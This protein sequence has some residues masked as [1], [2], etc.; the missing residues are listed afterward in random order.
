MLP[1]V[2]FARHLSLTVVAALASFAWIGDAF[3]VDKKPAT[4]DFVRDIRPLLSDNCFACHGPDSKKRKADLRL[5]TRE[6]AFA[7]LGGTTTIVHG[8]PNESELVI[9]IITD[10]ED[11]LMPPSDSGKKL[12]DSQKAL[13]KQWIVEGAQYDLHWAYKPITRPMPPSVKRGSFVVNDI[14]RLVLA[15][16]RAKGYEPAWEADR[17]TL[18][19]RLSFDLTGLP[20]TWEQVQSFVGDS[21]LH[22]F[23]KLVDRLLASPHYGERM[24]AFWLDLVRYAD[25]M[26]YH[27][28]NEQTK[29]LYREYVINAFNN[30]LPFDR[31]TR[32]QL[33]GDLLPD[34][35]RQQL[36]ASGYNRLN[37][38]TREGGSQ[39]KE[40]IAIYLGDRVRNVS[41]VWMATTLNC[42]ECHDHKFDPFSMRDY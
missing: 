8:K 9:R 29:P 31:F 41:A 38:T 14:D 3:A 11:D 25:T 40:Y 22:A 24:A 7:D 28:D 20:P 18:I 13:L 21:S 30:N 39:P 16:M 2:S 19:R 26:G 23:E 10:D 34:R 1:L 37:M 32:E 33:A 4:I 6:G 36:I 15:S 42:T 35:T 12:D 5:D 17:R 27:S